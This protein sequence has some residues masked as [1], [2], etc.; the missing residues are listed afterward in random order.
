MFN[1]GEMIYELRKGLGASQRELAKGIMSISELSRIE[2]GEKEA[3][4]IGL[5]ALFERLGK[6]L[7]KLELVI[8]GEDY[9]LRY[10]REEI[11]EKL[12]LRKASEVTYLL[13]IYD[14]YI[15]RKNILHRQYILEVR[16]INEC[17]QEKDYE[18]CF[19]QLKNAIELSFPE[20]K[21]GM[22]ENRYLCIQELRILIM[23]AHI[24]HCLDRQDQALMLA[25]EVREYVER[26]FTDD[27][28]KVKVFPHC[29]FVL[30]QSFYAMNWFEK[31]YDVCLQG[32]TCLVENG[33]LI[34]MDQ[35]LNLEKKC[36]SSMKRLEEMEECKK[37][38]DAILFLY[39]TVQIEPEPELLLLLMQSSMQ[40][41]YTVSSE[42]IHELR[43]TKGISQ[44]M[45]STNICAQETLSRIE[46]GRQ[47]P[48]TKNFYKIM[49]KMGE[50]RGT[51]WGYIVSP[52]Y[53]LFE[54]VRKY[55]RCIS[56]DYRTVVVQLLDEIQEELDMSIFA[57]RQFVEAGRI[58]NKI[59]TGE[60]IP[61]NAI[62]QLKELLYLTMP[63]LEKKGLIYRIPSRSE[64]FLANMIAIIYKN[65]GKCEETLSIY[66]QILQKYESSQGLMRHHAI[67][68]LVLYINYVS[69][70]EESGDLEKAEK[71]GQEGICHFL[72]CKRAD[73]IGKL[74][75][76][77]ACIYHKQRLP[78]REEAYLRNAYLLL[79][80]YARD[81]NSQVI[82]P[83]YEERFDTLL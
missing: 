1:L 67:P 29:M 3:D 8:S 13:N 58:E 27:E 31:A 24:L 64:F 80:L 34:L 55:N 15:E 46:Q 25:Q 70:L 72:Y 77:I 23:I 7:D 42:M 76:N 49:E 11:E 68:G 20:W 26:Q 38:R 39:Q 50:M 57:N 40:G 9:Q 28:A 63:P 41:E 4:Y 14:S 48:S 2:S 18:A 53:Y 74:L 54:K 37:Y 78:E 17:I 79:K 10:L 47:N 6:S 45:L 65:I 73:T 16:A 75:A 66:E 44:E 33:V 30:G 60:I 82:K 61:E 81:K 52:H 12:F 43:L 22:Q 62:G 83:V 71:I 21:K 36:C 56:M 59:S 35:L 19:E 69:A 51:Y 5:E 32:K